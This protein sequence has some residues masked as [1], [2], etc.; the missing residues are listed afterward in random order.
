[1]NTDKVRAALGALVKL[2][3]PVIVLSGVWSPSIEMV[4]GLQLALI[5]TIDTLFLLVPSSDT[6]SKPTP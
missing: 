1:M 5:A 4:A 2:W 6:M 3:L